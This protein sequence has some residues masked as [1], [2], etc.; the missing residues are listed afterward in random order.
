MQKMFINR[1]H[2]VDDLTEDDVSYWVDKY[3]VCIEDEVR[4][5]REH[6]KY[7]EFND[8]KENKEFIKEIIDILH[9]VVNLFIMGNSNSDKLANKYFE[10]Y[11]NNIKSVYDLITFIY[12]N[13]N[14]KYSCM[15]T[16]KE[17]LNEIKNRENELF[18]VDVENIDNA[19]NEDDG[20]ISI[21][22]FNYTNVTMLMLLN[23][24]LDN[25]GKVR[26]QINW[27]FWKKEK[28]SIDFDK[29]DECF[30]NL[31][32]SLIIV[33]KSIDCNPKT[34]KEIYIRKNMENVFRQEMNY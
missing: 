5:A 25:C 11:N 26:Q 20:Y 23:D 34:I 30:V 14:N 19:F 29:L 17:I 6:L 33:F 24:I 16:K 10:L 12:D 9:F 13:V 28:H 32:I 3:L 15:Y 21:Q 18:T 7:F 2:I 31:L 1:F 8:L 27:K 22:G 4:E